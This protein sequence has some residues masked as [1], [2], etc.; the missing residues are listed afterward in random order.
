MA[1]GSKNLCAATAGLIVGLMTAVS[2][3]STEIEPAQG[4]PE[5]VGFVFCHV[6]SPDVGKGLLYLFTPPFAQLVDDALEHSKKIAAARPDEKPPLGDGIPYQSYP[7]GA[8][9]C[10]VGAVGD[11]GEKW[12]V[13]IHRRFPDNPSAD[14]TDR[15]VLADWHGRL[16]I[17]DILYGAEGHRSGLRSVA[18]AV[19]RQ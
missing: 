19:L 6:A 2:S 15:L 3:F 9:V 11:A 18:E 5:F 10:E 8:P 12:R 16:L 17:D 4:S 1:N 13:E 14:W 7:D